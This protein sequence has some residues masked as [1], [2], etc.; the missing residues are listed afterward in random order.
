MAKRLGARTR[1]GGRG[2]RARCRGHPCTHIHAEF[3]GIL[4]SSWVI[5][6]MD[7]F[8][9]VLPI[10]SAFCFVLLSVFNCKLVQVLPSQKKKNSNSGDN[11]TVLGHPGTPQQRKQNW[12]FPQQN[13]MT[14]FGMGNPNNFSINRRHRSRT[15][16]NRGFHRPIWS[17]PWHQA[18]MPAP[19]AH[20]PF[21]RAARGMLLSC[22]WVP[23]LPPGGGGLRLEFLLSLL[24][25][26]RRETTRPILPFSRRS[27]TE[28]QERFSGRGLK[29]LS[30]ASAQQ[31]DPV[32][33]SQPARGF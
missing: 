2:Q 9:P 28:W 27:W 13:E 21:G 14:R 5:S 25:L 1:R 33:G 10:T 26:G 4:E 16:K 23:S 8:S 7:I 32:L 19:N 22:S 17:G 11:P 3:R 29:K 30:R 31:L 24:L 6:R 18:E 12:G 20:S 15:D